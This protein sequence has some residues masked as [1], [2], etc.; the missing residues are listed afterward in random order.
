MRNCLCTNDDTNNTLFRNS[1][2]TGWRSYQVAQAKTHKTRIHKAILIKCT[3]CDFESNGK[4]QLDEH[5][6]VVHTNNDD[7]RKRSAPK[8]EETQDTANS[9]KSPSSSPLRKKIVMSNDISE[10]SEI[11]EDMIV[12]D[13]SACSD[14]SVNHTELSESVD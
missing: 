13:K 7:A 5:T 10:N 1:K 11:V 14:D 8:S 3:L 6:E 2:P 9:D 4:T 12:D